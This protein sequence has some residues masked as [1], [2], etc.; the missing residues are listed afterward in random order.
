MISEVS[1][2]SSGVKI[3]EIVMSYLENRKK[4]GPQ[5]NF[6]EFLG[7]SSCRFEAFKL[8]QRWPILGL[9]E[10]CASNEGLTVALEHLP[11]LTQMSHQ[12][13]NRA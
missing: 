11:V 3:S 7:T 13:G 12:T 8:R 4:L 9:L 2:F 1:N 6:R 5:L 10:Y